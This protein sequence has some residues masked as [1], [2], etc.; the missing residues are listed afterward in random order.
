VIELAEA[1]AADG[2]GYMA[3]RTLAVLSKFFNWLVARDVLDFSPVTGV[4]R[5]HQEKARERILTDAELRALWLACD[6]DEP[7]GSALRLLILT[8]ARRNEVSRMTWSELDERWIWLLPAERSKN[9]LAHSIPLST[10]AQA[11]LM[12]Q[13]RIDG[14]GYVFTLDGYTAIRGWEKVKTRLSEKVGIAAAS[15]RLHDLRRTCASRMQ[16]LGVPVPV[17]ESALN[18]TSGTFRGIVGVYQQHDY[19]D[20]ICVAFQKWGDHVERLVEGKPAKVIALR[21]ARP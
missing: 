8:G 18:H 7:F 19:A 4:E 12:K 13:P 14:S 3:N 5:P 11:I 10:Q 20:E 9:G 17:I 16:K 6:G 2:R 21:E 1:I 15:W